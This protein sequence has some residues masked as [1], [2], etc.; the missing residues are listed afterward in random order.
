MFDDGVD[1]AGYPRRHLEYNPCLTPY[2]EGKE[3]GRRKRERQN[4]ND[5][6]KQMQ[7]VSE[8][9]VVEKTYKAEHEKH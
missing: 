5:P 2:T 7:D 3:H 8:T 6:R 4:N 9:A 1:S